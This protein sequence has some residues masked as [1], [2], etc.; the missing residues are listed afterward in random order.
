MDDDWAFGI[1]V[2][3]LLNLALV[4]VPSAIFF[5]NTIYNFQP[6]STDNEELSLQISQ[7]AL[8]LLISL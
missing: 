6:V 3:I 5:T 1:V 8:W 7:A 2:E 4:D